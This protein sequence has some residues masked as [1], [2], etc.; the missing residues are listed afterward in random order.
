[1][2]LPN[3]APPATALEY[4]YEYRRL[5]GGRYTFIFPRWYRYHYVSRANLMEW[6][7]LSYLIVI[8]FPNRGRSSNADIPR[9][10]PSIGRQR[11]NRG[12]HSNVARSHRGHVKSAP[13]LRLTSW[14]Y[15]RNGKCS[16]NDYDI[17]LLG[18]NT[19]PPLLGTKVRIRFVFYLFIS[20][21]FARFFYPFIIFVFH[22]F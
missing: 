3:C 5:S 21:V 12:V 14:E 17:T 9:G 18:S 4:T 13:S 11:L 16:H 6:V 20:F 10:G 8:A 2:L 1:M 22:L 19:S 15:G 7:T